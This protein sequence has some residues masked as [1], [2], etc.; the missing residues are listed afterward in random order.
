MA[1]AIK[2]SGR[3][4]NRE[5]AF[6]KAGD[7]KKLTG[8][9]CTPT[10]TAGYTFFMDGKEYRKCKNTAFFHSLTAGNIGHILK[11]IKAEIEHER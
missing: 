5:K 3:K 6:H 2:G 11:L 8:F 1:A 7:C 4:I 10:C 9:T